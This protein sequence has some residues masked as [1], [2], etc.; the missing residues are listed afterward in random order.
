MRNAVK[1]CGVGEGSGVARG[2]FDVQDLTNTGWAFAT[3][4][5]ALLATAAEQF[6]IDFNPTEVTN[7]AQAFPTLGM[8]TLDLKQSVRARHP[9]L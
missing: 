6:M 4:G 2:Q 8:R 3:A 9:Y 7:T 5:L 1:L